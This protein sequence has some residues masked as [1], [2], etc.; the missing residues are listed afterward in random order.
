MSSSYVLYHYGPSFA[1]AICFAIAFGISA[2]L[3]IWQAHRYGTRFMIAFIIGAILECLGYVARMINAKQTPDYSVGPYALQSLLLLLA[4]A[5]LAA[6]IYMILGRIIR[7]VDGEDRSPIRLGKLTKVFVTGDVLSFLIQSGGGAILSQAKSASKVH[8]GERIIIVGLFVQVLF[9]SVF[10]IVSILFHRNIHNNPTSKSISSLSSSS[11]LLKNVAG[12]PGWLLC[13]FILYAT[14]SLV[15]VRSIYRVVEYIQGTDGFLQSHEVF[16]YIFDAVL[17]L[18]VCA[19]LSLRH[20]GV[21]LDGS[22]GF[23]E[24]EMGMRMR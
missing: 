14:S 17:M 8:L 1:A 3:H 4:P 18:L 6:S 21:L 2:A 22:E 24:V 19:G 12:I 16:L 13:L 23:E 5:L 7:F 10:I 20:P 11:A 9:F 15:M